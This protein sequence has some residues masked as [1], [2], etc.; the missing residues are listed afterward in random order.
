MLLIATAH[1]TQEMWRTNTL[2]VNMHLVTVISVCLVPSTSQPYGYFLNIHLNLPRLLGISGIHS[3]IGFHTGVLCTFWVSFILATCLAHSN[4]LDF[5][6]Q[7]IVKIIQVMHK[8][9]DF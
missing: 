7:T 4:L 1:F 9:R 6:M 2:L 5:C 8:A 3:Q